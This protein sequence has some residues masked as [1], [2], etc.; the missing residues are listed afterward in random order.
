M[1]FENKIVWITGASSGIGEAC[2]YKF[3]KQGARVILSSNNEKELKEVLNKCLEIH[4]ECFVYPI[5]LSNQNSIITTVEQVIK[6]FGHIDIMFNNGGISQRALAIDTDLDLDRKIMEINYFGGITLTKQLL[7]HMIKYGSGHIVVNSSISGLFGF[8]L[9]SAY[10]AA[11]HAIHGFY[12]S[13]R[14]E[15]LEHNIACTIVCPGRVQTN[16]S[17][18]ALTKEGKAYGKM[19]DG[20]KNGISV[21]KA[22]RKIISAIRKKKVMALIGGKELLMVYLKRFF[23][24]LFYRLIVK[25]KST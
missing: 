13:L 17:L 5:E 1:S 15:L 10:S 11:K 12:E 20:Q 6:Q 22:A 24:R 18:H 19:D 21:D 8:P 25:V 16:I 7:P 14:I 23:P 4:S 9:R 2:A 3:M